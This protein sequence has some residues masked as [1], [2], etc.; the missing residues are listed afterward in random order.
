MRFPLSAAFATSLLA[1]SCSRPPFVVLTVEDPEQ[2]ATGWTQL[3]VGESAD[4]MSLATPSRHA[5][6]VS[7]TVTATI[8]SE[9]TL[10]VEAR[11][12]SGATLGRSKTLARFASAGT[13]TATV[14]L[15]KP[16][17]AAAGCDDGLFCT[18]VETCVDRV[19]VEG[20]PACLAGFAC[21]T[22]A[23]CAEGETQAECSFAVDNGLCGQGEY[24]DTSAGCSPGVG[25]TSDTQCDDALACNGRELCLRGKCEPGAPL[26]VSSFACVTETCAELGAGASACGITADH[27]K[28]GYGEYCNPAA[29]CVQGKGCNDATECQDG[30]Q[31]DGAEQ[32]V[33]LM[34]V[35]GIPPAVDD[36]DDCTVDGCNDLQTPAIFHL[37][38][39]DRDGNACTIPSV[40]GAGVCVAS[41]GGCVSSTCGDGVVFAAANEVCDDGPANLDV[42]SMTRHCNS[43]CSGHAGY[44][45]DGHTDVGHETC[46]DG[47]VTEDDNGCDEFCQ[48]NDDC[49]DGLVQSLFEQCDDGDAD[50]C[51]GCRTDCRRGCICATNQGCL[52]GTLCDTGICSDCATPAHCGMTCVACSGDKPLCEGVGTGC[53][54]SSIPAPRGSCGPGTFCS[55]QTCSGICNDTSHCGQECDTCGGNTPTCAGLDV[56]CIAD[57]CAGQ[58]DFTPCRV[59]TSPDWSFD[60]CSHE[61]CVSPGSGM[62]MNTPGPGFARADVD[63]LFEYPDTGQRKCYDQNG[64]EMSPCPSAGQA[65]FG[66]DA[67]YGWDQTHLLSTRFSRTEPVAGDTVVDDTVTGMMWQGC[68][69]GLYGSSCAKGNLQ[70]IGYYEARVYC[71]TLIWAGY[72]DWRLPDV[73]DWVAIADFGANWFDI[74]AFPG[75]AG[76]TCW[77]S[78]YTGNGIYV[79][80]NFMGGDDVRTEDYVRCVRK[81]VHAVSRF[82]RSEQTPGDGEPMVADAKTGLVWQGCAV[83]QSGSACGTG[84]AEPRTWQEA[85]SD[86][87]ELTWG[88]KSD[89]RLPN[90]KEIMSIA[91]PRGSPWF[92]PAFLP[93]PACSYWSSTSSSPQ[94]A[95]TLASMS[96][97]QRILFLASDKDAPASPTCARC[98]RQ[99]P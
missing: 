10:W 38:L 69:A 17:D 73:Y 45:G 41:K 63:P 56:G 9:K 84:T 30:Y 20:M 58:P 89:W 48:R 68:A 97:Y 94:L 59:V 44:C 18:G 60:I 75:P 37:A 3:A 86:C 31:C 52:A 46:D 55:G 66:Q 76:L 39:P 12:A 83:G 36:I 91:D 35:G 49:G 99:A 78:T 14:V 79:L 71:D 90:A 50:E 19:C 2:I 5:F 29:G 23:S 64:V 27:G 40:G 62:T 32:C 87:E 67:Q 13:P 92:D 80:S 42:W 72:S 24:C 1:A 96:A 95:V 28:C 57:S 85:L 8:T 26:C 70:Y 93:V 16:C 15:G 43:T 88:Q 74:E 4:T 6:P 98:V 22:G 53:V 47:N 65:F 33:N 25:C 51:N 11:N 54:C 82:A 21:V 61:V 77:S 34:C 81:G 7:I